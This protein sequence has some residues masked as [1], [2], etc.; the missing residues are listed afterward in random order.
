MKRTRL[1]T[2]SSVGQS[3]ARDVFI[4]LSVLIDAGETGK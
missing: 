3:K 1:R 4:G 2:V